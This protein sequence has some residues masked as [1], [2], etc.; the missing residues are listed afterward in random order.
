MINDPI[1]DKL[2][3]APLSNR[4]IELIAPDKTVAE[5]IQDDL[6]EVRANI[7]N[8][9]TQGESALEELKIISSSSQDPKAYREFSV[10]TKVLLDAN[11][12]L[13]EAAK[14][15]HDMNHNKD[16][17]MVPGETTVHNN[18]LF[19]GSTSEAIELIKGKK[20]D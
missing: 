9:I 15:R 6:D 13:I 17:K 2:E 20:N 11:K 4:A 19:V 5:S 8:L 3:L 10:L 16:E 18:N 12:S 7:Q 1:Y 14:A